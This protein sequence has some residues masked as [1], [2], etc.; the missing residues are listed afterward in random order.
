MSKILILHPTCT[1]M[2]SGADQWESISILI[3]SLHLGA[4]IQGYKA[5]VHIGPSIQDI[6]FKSLTWSIGWVLVTY[7]DISHQ[8]IWKSTHRSVFVIKVQSYTSL[9]NCA[10]MRYIKVVII[11]MVIH[12]ECQWVSVTLVR[13]QINILNLFNI[14]I[15]IWKFQ[16]YLFEYLIWNSCFCH[17][18]KV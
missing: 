8:I 14:S 15:I 2:L 3:N 9:N 7:S 12:F 6:P 5:I 13:A 11:T 18:N 17:L 10:Q 1:L 4:Q 16:V